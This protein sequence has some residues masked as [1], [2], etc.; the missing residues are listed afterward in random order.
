[1]TDNPMKRQTF[2][3]DQLYKYVLG[4]TVE[5]NNSNRVYV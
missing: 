1:M 5:I 4:N 3:C 2:E